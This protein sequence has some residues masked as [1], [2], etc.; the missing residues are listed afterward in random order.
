MNKQDINQRYIEVTAHDLPLA[1]PMPNMNVWNAHPKVMIPL[2]HGGEARCPY[3]GTL[4]K[5]KGELPKAHH[6]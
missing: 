1:C 3:C 4:Y 6:Q 2:D 5:F